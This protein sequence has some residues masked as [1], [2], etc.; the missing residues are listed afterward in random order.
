MR[1]TLDIIG[2]EIGS[3]KDLIQCGVG[4]RPP[5]VFELRLD[6][7]RPRFGRNLFEEDGGTRLVERAACGKHVFHQRRLRA[8]KDITD[9]ALSLNFIPKN[10]FDCLSSKEPD[11]L[12]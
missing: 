11:L 7:I 2:N 3:S 5:A 6:E 8:G 10:I 4:N 1:D 12:E 9:I